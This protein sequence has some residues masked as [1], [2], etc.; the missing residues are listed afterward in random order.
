MRVKELFSQR[1]NFLENFLLARAQRLEL[2]VAV[3]QN[4]DGGG[5]SKS[6]W[7]DGRRRE[8]LRDCGRRCREP[9]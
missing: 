7:R 2:A 1:H 9:N 8:R 4:A 6:R 5:E 3:V